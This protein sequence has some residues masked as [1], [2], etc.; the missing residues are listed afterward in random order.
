MVRLEILEKADTDWNCRISQST[1]GRYL[2]T[3]HHAER[4]LRY[5]N[6]KPQF[7]I[8]TKGKDVVGQQLLALKPR[9]T[10]RIK[11]I[12]G[13][14]TKPI[15][16]W[17]NS[18]LIFDK[19][20]QDEILQKFTSFIKDK[21]YSGTDNPI[22]DYHLNLPKIEIGTV[23]IEIKKTF[24]ETISGRDPTSTQKHIAMTAHENIPSRKGVT[25]KQIETDDEIKIYHNML[26]EHRKNLRIKSPDY[27]KN[28][29]S[30]RDYIHTLIKNEYGGGLL[31][32]HNNLPISGIIYFN[33]NG[34]IQNSDVANT[35]YSL[36]NKLSSLDYLR[37]SLISMGVK[38][39][40]K[41]F[42]VGGIALN[43]KNDKEAGIR[44]SQTKWG[45]KIAKFNKYSNP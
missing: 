29:D 43:P 8:F 13:K 39:S 23:I 22:A 42:D 2:Q 45:G 24:E 19:G 41:F 26:L 33:Y 21:K 6:M 10:T 40:A 36:K 20:Y 5:R 4:R 7:M 37:C 17:K 44:H 28:Y 38:T 16:F 34:W 1:S 35:K 14:M 11:K 25:A 15:Y 18:I 32:Y 30:V 31:A 27:V 12:L 9:G 3:T